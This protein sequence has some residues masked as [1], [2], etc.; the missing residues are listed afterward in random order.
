LLLFFSKQQ[1]FIIPKA[2]KTKPALTIKG[3]YIF[4]SKKIPAIGG[5][6]IIA[7]EKIADKIPNASPLF[8][9]LE[10]SETRLVIIT[11]KID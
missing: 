10:I 3:N 11:R 2:P 4:I 8:S 9:W 6:T 7:K 1:Y 5:A